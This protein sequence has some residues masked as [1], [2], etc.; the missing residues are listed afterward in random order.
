[1][2]CGMLCDSRM[3][4]AGPL[5]K[6]YELN[7]NK[8]MEQEYFYNVLV[9]DIYTKNGDPLPPIKMAAKQFQATTFAAPGKFFEL[10]YNLQSEEGLFDDDKM[11]FM[12]EIF[13]TTKET[14]DDTVPNR[15]ELLFQ[16][17]PYK[18]G[19]F[20]FIPLSDILFGQLIVQRTI[21]PQQ[22]GRRKT[23]RSK[24]TR[25]RRTNRK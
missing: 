18:E 16:E 6:L 9:A 3:L 25:R 1:M 20:A 7:R 2:S 19:I 14:D 23:R 10:G 4:T 13:K 17:S 24:N 5:Y 11:R 12:F 15:L 21:V 22:G 8:T